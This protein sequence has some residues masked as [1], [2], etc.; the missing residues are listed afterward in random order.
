MVSYKGDMHCL[1]A[2]QR[3]LKLLGNDLR[4]SGL[5]KC[6]DA[7]THVPYAACCPTVYVS[8]MIIYCRTKV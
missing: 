1:Y 5:C 6:K 2:D 3:I 7:G 8:I 4:F